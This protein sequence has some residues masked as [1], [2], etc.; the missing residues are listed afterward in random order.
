MFRLQKLRRN[1]TSAPR[2]GWHCVQQTTDAEVPG[3][4]DRRRRSARD[5][6]AFVEHAKP[7][8]ERERLPHVVRH[9]DHGLFQP[10]LNP[11]KLGVQEEKYRVVTEGLKGEEWVVVSGLLRAIPGRQVTPEKSPGQPG[12]EG[13]KAPESQ[14]KPKKAAP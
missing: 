3:R 13:A 10:I 9:D 1:W 4:R 8:A 7:R 12:G 5:E 6:R 11:V 14:P 2:H